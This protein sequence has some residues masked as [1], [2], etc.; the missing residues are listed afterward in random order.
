[1]FP[2]RAELP[3]FTAIINGYRAVVSGSYIN[4]APV[5]TDSS[6][7]Y[8]GIQDS[9]GIG[10]AIFGEVFLKSQYVVFDAAGLRMAFAPQS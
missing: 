9:A 8:G 7:C 1:M 4:F 2:C 5:S 3:S 10:F 6:V